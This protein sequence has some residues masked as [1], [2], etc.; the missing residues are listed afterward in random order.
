MNAST[1]IL[2][3]CLRGAAKSVLAAV[4][5]RRL[6]V[7]RGLDV[8]VDSAG[9][10]PDSAVAPGVVRALVTEGLD[11]GDQRPRKVTSAD[12]GAAS[13]IVAFG[14]DLSDITLAGA[15]VEQ[16]TGVPPVS[17][18]LQTARAAIRQHLERLPDACAAG[19]VPR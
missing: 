9:T 11:L 17:D 8:T 15:A 1:R 6:A 18:D 10:E 13:R 19:G 14:C 2:F 7:E 4:D 3:V 16:W 5:C 12:V